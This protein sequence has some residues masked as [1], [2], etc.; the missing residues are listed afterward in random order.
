[1]DPCAREDN[2]IANK[3][4][5]QTLMMDLSSLSRPWNTAFLLRLSTETLERYGRS[6][7]VC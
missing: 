4:P 1:M 5:V 7:S 3:V 6:C 2:I